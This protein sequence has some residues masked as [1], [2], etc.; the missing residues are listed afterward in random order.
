MTIRVR[1]KRR[2]NLTL[3]EVISTLRE[4]RQIARY[5][6]NVTK[7]SIL[8]RGSSIMGGGGRTRGDYGARCVTKSESVVAHLEHIVSRVARSPTLALICDPSRATLINYPR[9]RADGHLRNFE[10]LRPDASAHIRQWDFSLAMR[11]RASPR[12]FLGER[13]VQPHESATLP[14]TFAK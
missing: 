6:Q 14:P 4:T 13:E 2:E 3:L 12:I 10:S 1:E 8:R 9:F 5:A 7:V 11:A